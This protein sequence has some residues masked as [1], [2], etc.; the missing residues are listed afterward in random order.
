MT[1]SK[2]ILAGAAAVILVAAVAVKWFFFP[3][4]KD[5]YFAMNQNSLRQVPAGLVAVRPT[6]FS[7][8]PRK[9]TLWASVKVSGKDVWRMMGRN[10]SFKEL[11]AQAYGQPQ[12]RV[13]LPVGAPTNNFDF[14]VTE[15]GD[16]R[17]VLQ[18]AVRKKPGYTAK[19]E[20][21]DEDVLALKVR[22]ASLPGLTVSDAST[23][24]NVHFDKGKLYFTHMRLQEI[25]GGL[26]QAV[27]TPV[28]DKTDLTNFYD[29]SVVWDQQMQRQ[30][31]DD[32]AA[33]AAM[34][35]IL[36]GW[37]IE[38]EPDNDQVEMLVVKSASL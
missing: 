31:R 9:G 14:L 20:T 37:G 12:N 10:V 17:E 6:K 18:T 22:D 8:S 25:T 29:F 5:A 27:K 32:A 2:I 28:V 3:S 11:M 36:N 13:M 4:I 7:N 26:E 30:M 21:H 33:T 23:R 16:L 38:L 34:K 19:M 1:R 15:R 35:K 24:Q